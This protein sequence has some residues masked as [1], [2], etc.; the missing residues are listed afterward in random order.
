MQQKV[1]DVAN[2]LN[3]NKT[4]QNKLWKLWGYPHGQISDKMIVLFFFLIWPKNIQP[5][6]HT[7][8]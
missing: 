2:I 8:N 7:S 5:T 3:L 6:N 1:T 4:K